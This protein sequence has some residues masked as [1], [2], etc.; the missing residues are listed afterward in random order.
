MIF[1][2]R[3]GGVSFSILVTARASKAMICGRQG[4]Y[5]R[6][7]VS[8]PPVDN[9]ANIECTALLAD[10]F[11]TSKSKVSIIKGHTSRRKNVYIEGVLPS[12]AIQI[13]NEHII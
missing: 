7:K 1:K 13:L 5:I 6:I 9:K 11:H 12:Q 4:E 10:I 2:E 3:D 8:S